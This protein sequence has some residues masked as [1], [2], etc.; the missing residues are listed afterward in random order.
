MEQPVST[1]SAGAR[2]PLFETP[3]EDSREH[4]LMASACLFALALLSGLAT[5]AAC[6][7]VALRLLGAAG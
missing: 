6:G 3:S 5:C 7:F 2:A 4:V 1:Y